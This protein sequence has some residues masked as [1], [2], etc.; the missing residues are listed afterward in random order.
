M[1][2]VARLPAQDR[3]DL[4]RAAADR[5]GVTSAIIEKDFWVC[6]TLRRLY[7][8][9]T[10]A[11]HLYFK[12]GTSL[13][14]VFG[15]IER[16]SEDIDLVIDR[17]GLGFTGDRDPA[18]DSISGKRRQR[19]VTEI[20]SEATRFVHSVLAPALRARIET[21]LADAE[22]WSLS[23][24]TTEP[25]LLF[26]YPRIE[27]STAYVAPVV[28]L[29]FGARGDPWPSM[30]GVVRPYAADQLP[31]LFSEPETTIP[32]VV[33]AERTFWEKAT[34][35]HALHY[36]PPE[37]PIADRM[38]R[39]YYDLFRLA[40]RAEWRGAIA[41]LDLL[42]RVVAHKAMF[43]RSAAASYDLAKPGTLRLVPPA[44]RHAELEADYAVMV[45]EMLFG[46]APEWPTV[47]A[48]LT[49]IE[50]A[51]NHLPTSAE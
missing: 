33:S 12:G 8:L 17:H 1:D 50:N 42:R 51:I 7:S 45:E 31:A 43:F 49:E 22:T 15:A 27:P 20:Q 40:S 39:H 10:L 14:K 32:R 19:L 13:S 37:K 46:D 47:I 6:W 5:L 38:A 36:Q 34:I 11:D 4:F 48:R 18:T 21:A 29:E 41:D 16:M 3:S 30:S 28:R 44:N 35:L 2:I 24:A 26:A 23:I 25:T 9:P